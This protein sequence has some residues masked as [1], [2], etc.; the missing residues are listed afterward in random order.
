M[1]GYRE[2][3]REGEKIGLQVFLGAEIALDNPYNDYLLFGITEEF[4]REYP[5]LFRLEIKDLY[6]LGRKA[7]A[8]WFIK[9]I[10]SARV[11]HRRIPLSSTGSRSLTATPGMT[12]ITGLLIISPRNTDY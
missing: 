8:S 2:A 1:A 10:L 12:P 7:M 3:R 4:L 9:P 5:K 11:F 6:E